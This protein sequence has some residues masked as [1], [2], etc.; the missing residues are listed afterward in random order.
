ML[1]ISANTI[2]RPCSRTTTHLRPAL[3]QAG[4]IAAILGDANL[5]LLLAAAV[6]MVVYIRQRGPSRETRWPT[7]SKPR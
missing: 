2:F 3:Q 6:A 5:A 1:L 4:D 7:W